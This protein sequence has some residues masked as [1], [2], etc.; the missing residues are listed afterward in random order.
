MKV[1]E[2]QLYDIAMARDGLDTLL[3]IYMKTLG[4]A[5]GTPLSADITRNSMIADI[6][7]REYPSGK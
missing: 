4:L 7:D 1:R 3:A 2:N 5:V 6:L